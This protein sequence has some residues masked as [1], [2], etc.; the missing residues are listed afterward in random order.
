MDDD[1]TVVRGLLRAAGFDPPDADLPA[2]AQSYAA[3]RQMVGL[4]YTVD[5]ARDEWPALRFSAET[6]AD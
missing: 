1:L 5:E 6:P 4:L 3:T 2:L